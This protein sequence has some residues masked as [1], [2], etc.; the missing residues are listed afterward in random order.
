M[1]TTELQRYYQKNIPKS[2]KFSMEF[3]TTSNSKKKKSHFLHKNARYYG[4]QN[5]P[6][7]LLNVMEQIKYG[8]MNH[9]LELQ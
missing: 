7:Y 3:A 4:Y 1:E 5:F 6:N 2:C 9:F 8:L